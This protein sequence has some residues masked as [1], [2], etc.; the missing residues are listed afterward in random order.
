MYFWV[1]LRRYNWSY[2]IIIQP[3]QISSSFQSLSVAMCELDMMRDCLVTLKKP[4]YRQP[5]F[6]AVNNKNGYLCN[7]CRVSMYII[8]SI[9]K[10][11][12]GHIDEWR[13][14]ISLVLV[15]VLCI[16]AYLSI[17]DKVRS[18][19]RVHTLRYFVFVYYSTFLYLTIWN[20]NILYKNEINN[21]VTTS[22]FISLVT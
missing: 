6:Y 9:K 11:N 1:G 14:A 10:Q 16:F 12:V 13:T 7:W 3:L 18:Q 17:M 8:Y 2:S 4:L 21:I 5:Y 22:S 15:N 20:D 19:Q